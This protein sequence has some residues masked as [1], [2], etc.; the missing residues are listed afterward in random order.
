[1]LLDLRLPDLTGFEV[2]EQLSSDPTTCDIPIII[3]SGMER[4]DVVRLSRAA[5]CRF[6]LRKPYD[7][8]SLL[9]LVEH[10]LLEAEDW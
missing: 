9:C 1:M 3:V 8:N 4:P 2:C 6:Y 5:G 10:A 7:P